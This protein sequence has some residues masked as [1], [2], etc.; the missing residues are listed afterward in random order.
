M[1][2]KTRKMHSVRKVRYSLIIIVF[3]AFAMLQLWNLKTFYKEARFELPKMLFSAAKS[4]PISEITVGKATES[5][6][7]AEANAVNGQG[8]SSQAD[9]SETGSTAGKTQLRQHYRVM[10]A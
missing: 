4:L 8:E 5:V 9:I 7:I 6:D 3:I 2:T 10:A 1:E